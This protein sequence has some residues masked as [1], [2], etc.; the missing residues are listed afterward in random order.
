M[1]VSICLGYSVCSIKP[2]K[3]KL[4]K[5][6]N[7]NPVLFLHVSGGTNGAMANQTIA[8]QSA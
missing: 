1:V 2:R 7:T 5:H 4:R 6:V 3:E 8:K